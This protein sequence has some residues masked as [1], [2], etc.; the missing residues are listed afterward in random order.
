MEMAPELRSA[1]AQLR[2]Q[3]RITDAIRA[4][5]RPDLSL[6]AELTGRAG[7]ASVRTNSTPVGGG[8]VPDV[9]NWD[10]LVV[11]SWPIF[12]RTVTERAKTS[13]RIEAVRAAEIDQVVE[14][15][16]TLDARGFIELDV[17]RQ[18][19]PA[20]QRA[21]DAAEANHAQAE[22]RFTGGLGT[23][24]ELSDAEALL[25]DTQS[26]LA[27]GQFQLSRARARLGRLISE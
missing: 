15:L 22:A 16:A 8:F 14:Q 3:Q 20:L 27:I 6:S 11:F 21:L 17:A 5:L 13:K 19:L 10:A 26:Q 18:A 23:A 12:D 7:G 1:Q 4:E 25:T 2:A 24:I 9:P